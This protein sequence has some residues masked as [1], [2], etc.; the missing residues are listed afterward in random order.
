MVEQA[1]AA[2]MPSRSKRKADDISEKDE[3]HLPQ[4]VSPHKRTPFPL[5]HNHLCPVPA[6]RGNSALYDS[7]RFERVREDQ[8]TAEQARAQSVWVCVPKRGEHLP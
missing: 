3:F 2:K 4:I 1:V 7:R 8:A 5:T 6:R